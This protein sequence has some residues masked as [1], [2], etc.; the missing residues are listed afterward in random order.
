MSATVTAGTIPGAQAGS[1][2]PGAQT[3]EGFVG[4]ALDDAKISPLHKRVVA[5]IAAG[6]FCDVIDFTVFG[7]L[8]PFIIK[9]GFG[10]AADAA[11]IGSA[12]IFGLALGT[13]GQGEFSDRF[14]RRFI[15]Q[16][17][18]LLFGVFTILGALAPSLTLLVIC[19]FIA[20][21][22]LGAEQPLAFAYAGEYAPK[23]I[24]GRVLAIVHFIG[25]ACVWP[26]GTGLVL[27]FGALMAA[28][29]TDV[30][31]SAEYVWRG[32]WILI[33]VLALV[34]WVF[35][36]TLP[37][38]PRYLATHGRG[39]EAIKVLGR[40]GIAGPTQ[41]LS[42]DAASNTKSDPFAVV[43]KMFPTRVIAGMI[44]FSAFFGI[45][46]GL[47]AWLP[48]IMNGKGFSIT[49]SLQYT[50]AMN[51]AVPCASLFMMYALDK[52]GRKITSVL[53]FVAAG[54]MALVFANAETAMELMVAGFIMIFF[55]QVAG[56]SM[57][58]FA[59]EV[60]PT[61]AR[62]SGFGWAAGTGRLATA[63]IM[64]TILWVQ[65]GFGLTTVF[66]CLATLLFIAAIAVTQL[67]PEARQ[68]SLDEIAPPTG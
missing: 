13:A 27:G 8:V 53:A 49:K 4:Q 62:A 28:N 9:S 18:L 66:A 38:S 23:R 22:G 33:G 32:V 40:L 56:N 16:F 30:A 2:A 67:G 21:I 3:Y 35:R 61:N 6:Y 48:N 43:F 5:L 41:P 59:S 54:L 7:S 63:F 68:R 46:I 20:G 14:G 34:V 11:L 39:D 50:L 25:G 24:R 64:P 10:V 36:F 58:I 47:G 51:F 55:V 12:T 29:Y 31:Q 57:Q 1:R 45:A 42:S 37:E 65:T 15:Y 26:I 60:F 17:N 44:C 19:R 52:Y